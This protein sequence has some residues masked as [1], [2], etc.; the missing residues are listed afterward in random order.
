MSGSSDYCLKWNDHHNV[1]FS[2][3]EEL[4]GS[5]ILCDVSLSAGDKIFQ[6]HK[7]VLSVCSPYFKRVF[8]VSDRSVNTII[9]MKNVDSRH[10]EL[11]LAYMYRGELTLKQTELVQFLATAKDLQVK[12]LSEMDQVEAATDLKQEYRKENLQP[13]N[14]KRKPDPAHHPT[15]LHKQNTKHLKTETT[16]YHHHPSPIPMLHPLHQL[17]PPHHMQQL[18]AVLTAAHQLR[19]GNSGSPDSPQPPPASPPNISGPVN[20]RRPSNKKTDGGDVDVVGGGSV[21]EG[22]P[23]LVDE[24]IIPEDDD[25][26]NL[27]MGDVQ[28][29]KYEESEL[30]ESQDLTKQTS[31]NLTKAKRLTSGAG[32]TNTKIPPVQGS[33]KP[34]QCGM[35]EMAF[36]QKWLLKRH[37]RTHTKERPFRCMLCMK[38][39]SL[40]DS[41]VRHIR[42]VHREEI[43][44]GATVSDISSSY[45]QYDESGGSIHDKDD[46]EIEMGSNEALAVAM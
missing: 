46:L 7:L 11:I 3:A 27:S 40:K 19:V 34:F 2:T 13:E 1:F 43:Y 8:A 6:A 36:D 37:Y 20:L 39:F 4:C 10:L 38:N 30:S 32:I 45:C 29:V 28:A 26:S 9:H 41:C 14:L 35:C 5:N 42:N 22:G 15:D 31:T 16:S 17:A 21:G 18:G 23:L 25:L 12:G 24:H 44:G 33:T